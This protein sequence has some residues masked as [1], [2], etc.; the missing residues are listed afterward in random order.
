MQRRDFTLGAVFA[1][2]AALSSAATPQGVRGQVQIVVPFPPG[3]I[4]DTLARV[5]GE[6]LSRLWGQVVV[7]EDR[8]GASGYIAA[9]YVSKAEPSG[10]TL[11]LGT[12]ALLTINPHLIKTGFDPGRELVPITTVGTSDVV[13]VVN[14][15][16][17]ASNLQELANYVKGKPEGVS[18]GSPSSASTQHLTGELLQRQLG[19]K[20]VHVAYKGS[21]PA[22]ND[23]IAGHIPMMIDNIISALPHIRSGRLRALSV[24]GTRRSAALQDVPTFQE[25]GLAGLTTSAWFPLLGPKGMAADLV[26]GIQHDAALVLEQ[27]AVREQLLAQGV[28]PSGESTAALQA[29]IERDLA[30]WKRVIAESKITL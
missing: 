6:A 14:P 3:G 11:L 10:R 9:E 16:M 13:V 20:L 12:S 15:S 1:A 23:V 30:R 2:G 7:V 29:R 24:S 28:D 25:S 21:A 17:P 18:Y 27:P 5:M 8:P 22:L 19:V 26:S 4:T